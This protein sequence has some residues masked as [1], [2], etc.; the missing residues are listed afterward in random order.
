MLSQLLCAEATCAPAQFL[1]G[2]DSVET[3]GAGGAQLGTTGLE[4]CAWAGS[5]LRLQ[6][7]GPACVGA[8]VAH[9]RRPRDPG[10]GMAFL[11]GVSRY[12]HATVPSSPGEDTVLVRHVAVVSAAGWGKRGFIQVVKWKGKGRM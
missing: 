10:K 6:G 3:P 4:T 7:Q 8:C 12:C 2:C 1:P 5:C 11:P 9:Q